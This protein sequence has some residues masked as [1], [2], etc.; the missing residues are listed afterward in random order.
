MAKTRVM[1][2]WDQETGTINLGGPI[3]NKVLMYGLL[4]AAADT[5]RKWH[6]DEARKVKEAKPEEVTSLVGLNGGKG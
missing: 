2:E 4:G 6:E 3:Q 5:V 1:I